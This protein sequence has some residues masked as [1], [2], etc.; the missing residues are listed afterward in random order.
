MH[1]FSI[2]NG[3]PRWSSVF[4]R[5]AFSKW[6]SLI[7]LPSE[8]IRTVQMMLRWWRNDVTGFISSQPVCSKT[9]IANEH[10]IIP[11]TQRFWSN[12]H[13]RFFQHF[14]RYC[15]PR[16]RDSIVSP[17][18]GKTSLGALALSRSTYNILAAYQPSC[19]HRGKKHPKHAAPLKSQ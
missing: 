14:E 8:F 7:L 1:A 5:F 16:R 15:W 2:H 9:L 4:L 10:N 13:R 19:D 18:S 6:W 12:Q 11:G 3:F 17:P